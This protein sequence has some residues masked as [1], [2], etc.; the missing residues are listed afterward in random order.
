MRGQMKFI[1]LQEAAVRS[2]VLSGLSLE[3]ARDKVSELVLYY[4]D[5]DEATKAFKDLFKI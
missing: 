2:L 4:G 1:K 5:I 3:Q